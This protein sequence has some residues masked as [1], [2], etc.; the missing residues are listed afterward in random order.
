MKKRIDMDEK[1]FERLMRERLEETQEFDFRAADWEEV[2]GQLKKKGPSFLFWIIGSLLLVSFLGLAYWG[3]SYYE[4]YQTKNKKLT[5]LIDEIAQIKTQLAACGTQII[6]QKDTVY[7]TIVEEKYNSQKVAVSF[8]DAKNKFAAAPE[9]KT[10][11]STFLNKNIERVAESSSGKESART[12]ND[13]PGWKPGKLKLLEHIGSSYSGLSTFTT[14][15]SLPTIAFVPVQKINLDQYNKQKARSI[16]VGLN[17]GFNGFKSHS[18][19]VDTGSISIEGRQISI[20]EKGNRS[21]GFMADFSLA[22]GLYLGIG[23]HYQRSIY[24]LSGV[25]SA[26]TA[27][28]EFPIYGLGDLEDANLEQIFWNIHIDLKYQFLQRSRIRPI[29]GFR[30]AF[31]LNFKQ[32]LWYRYFDGMEAEQILSYQNNAFWGGLNYFSPMIGAEFKLTERFHLL[33]ESL[34]HLPLNQNDGVLANQVGV[35]FGFFYRLR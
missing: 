8:T 29:L 34:Y 13:K 20:L 15:P 32:D 30:T 5:E 31:N 16:R 28:F 21:L 17:T 14:K 10:T 25:D 26:W 27:N 19:T 33:A 23:G 3:F 35:N 18:N 24:R 2:A 9:N 12:P 22:K 11:S 4:K 1:D 6:I 7:S